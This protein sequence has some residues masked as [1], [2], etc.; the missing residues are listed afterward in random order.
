MSEQLARVE[1]GAVARPV[2]SV[3]EM[4][5]AVIERGVTAENVSAIEKLVGLYERM[6]QKK[7]EREFAEAFVRLQKR[8]PTIPG[9]RAVPDKHGN[10]KYKYADFDDID[11][12]VRPICLEEKF[13]YSF[14]ETAMDGGR[15]TMTMT[16]QH[17]SGYSRE[18]PYS[19]RVGDGPPGASNSQAD[20]SG[21]T[22]AKRGAIESGL[23]LRVVGHRDDAKMEGN[24][25]E[26]VTLEQADELERRAQESNSNIAIFLKCAGASSF[27]TI[28]ANRYAEMD[29]MLRLKEQGKR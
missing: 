22:Y 26:K 15:V 13:T 8:L 27:A 28:P 19:V 29:R 20:V 6:E 18:I 16:L 2:P 17:S 23:S 14:R 5:H 10:T 11:A 12:I 9:F 24:P 4:L 1:T 7:S 3:G 25:E 21:H